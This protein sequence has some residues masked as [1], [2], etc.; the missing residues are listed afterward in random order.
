MD[1]HIS[2]RYV[3]E[4]QVATQNHPLFGGN[5][6]TFITRM[7]SAFD[8]VV[9][10]HVSGVVNKCINTCVKFLQGSVY[11]TIKSVH[12]WL[13]YRSNYRVAFLLDNSVYDWS[14]RQLAVS[15]KE[16][17]WI[18]PVACVYCRR[19]HI[20][21]LLNSSLVLCW[22]LRTFIFYCAIST[23]RKTETEK[24][25]WQWAGHWVR[26]LFPAFLLWNQIRAE[27][28]LRQGKQVYGI[29]V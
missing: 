13:K 10:W 4:I 21:R 1:C 19:R 27:D 14:F 9:R 7:S 28:D 25:V 11:I 23:R 15:V 26:I 17:H 22:L 29:T 12:F 8:K 3:S 16:R 18:R 24:A 2:W 5:N 6:I 20:G